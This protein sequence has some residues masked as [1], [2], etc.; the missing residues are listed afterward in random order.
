MRVVRRS[1]PGFVRASCSLCGGR[2]S[3]WPTGSWAS[4]E[5]PTEGQVE[6]QAPNHEAR[7]IAL[8]AYFVRETLV[9]AERFERSTS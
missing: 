5:R 2:T 6:G 4:D 3:T 7:R 1:G 8:R 9:G